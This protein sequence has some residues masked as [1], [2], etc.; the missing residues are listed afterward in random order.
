MK[1][2][3]YNFKAILLMTLLLGLISA[4]I[5]QIL[6]DKSYLGGIIVGILASFF[7]FAIFY[8][9]IV[10]RRGSFGDYLSYTTKINLN[11]VL[12]S[13]FILL[14]SEVLAFIT[15]AGMLV[16]SMAKMQNKMMFEADHSKLFFGFFVFAILSLIFRIIMTY[17]NLVV[18][19]PRNKDFSFI[20]ALKQILFLGR[21]LLGKTIGTMI[22]KLLLPILI[23]VAFILII[24]FSSQFNLGPIGFVILGLGSLVFA[25]V[26]LLRVISYQAEISDHYL[27]YI[28]DYYN[29]DENI[30]EED[31]QKY[32]I[33]RTY[34]IEDENNSYNDNDDEIIEK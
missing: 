19:D 17:S 8:G 32:T 34:E 24:V 18:A 21:E 25:I 12:V 5:S 16:S 26:F 10:N 27:N 31:N 29:E 20:K 1:N 7:N 3:A 14:V 11:F 6:G 15:G 23:Y 28:G 9:L 13:V 30:Y 4:T 33:K 22:K 2:R